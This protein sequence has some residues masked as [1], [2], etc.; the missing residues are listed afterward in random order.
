MHSA[1]MHIIERLTRVGNEIRY[2]MT[3]EDPEY[4]IEP[5][6]MP[7]RV[8]RPEVATALL[9]NAGIAKCTRKAT[10]PRNFA[11]NEKN[12]FGVCPRSSKV[13]KPLLGSS[14]GRLFF[15]GFRSWRKE[16]RYRLDMENQPGG[17]PLRHDL[18]RILRRRSGKI[19]P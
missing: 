3:I 15:C 17:E 9:R 4:F 7:T 10:S 6:V 5:W 18:G 12:C 2:D 19:V 11:T 1:D 13:E 16:P 14:Q 8:L